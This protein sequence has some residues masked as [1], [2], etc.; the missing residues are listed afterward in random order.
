MLDGLELPRVGHAPVEQPF[1]LGLHLAGERVDVRFEPALVR[2]QLFDLEFQLTQ[3]IFRHLG[4]PPSV[5]ELAGRL[6]ELLA[7]LEPVERRV[8]L[9]QL[10]QALEPPW[11][12]RRLRLDAH[13]EVA[14][15][16]GSRLR[17]A[18]HP[19]YIAGLIRGGKGM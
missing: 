4:C 9:L 13:G 1:A 5:A 10:E 14:S 19:D 18:A 16:I 7:P 3:A 8:Q 17:L 12:L 6:Q 15:H 2:G 11:T